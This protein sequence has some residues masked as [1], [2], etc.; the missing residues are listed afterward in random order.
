MEADEWRRREGEGEAAMMF[1]SRSRSLHSRCAVVCGS[2]VG[3]MWCSFSFCI[4]RLR[5]FFLRWCRE[6]GTKLIGLMSIGPL[7]QR[8]I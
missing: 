8:Y 4:S 1:Q 3:V 6:R 5:N 2:P 7:I